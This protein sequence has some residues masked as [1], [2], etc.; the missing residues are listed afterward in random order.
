MHQK[1]RMNPC[2][3]APLARYERTPGR[4]DTR[5]RLQ[6][7][8]RPAP[9]HKRLHV[10]KATAPRVSDAFIP[11]CPNAKPTAA[12]SAA[13]CSLLTSVLRS[14]ACPLL[15]STPAKF[16]KSTP[17]LGRLTKDHYLRRLTR[18][19]GIQGRRRVTPRSRLSSTTIGMA[20]SLQLVLRNQ[21]RQTTTQTTDGRMNLSS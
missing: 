8:F 17:Y 21:C 20:L 19:I 18:L 16:P 5:T 7:T 3:V 1:G 4:S 9:F 13:S 15:C 11:P 14:V 10:H 2:D 12:P 6:A